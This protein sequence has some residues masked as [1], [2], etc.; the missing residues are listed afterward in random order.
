MTLAPELAGGNANRPGAGIFSKPDRTMNQGKLD[1]LEASRTNRRM[2]C[3]V[4]LRCFR[5]YLRYWSS[6]T[7]S[8]QSTVLP[9]S[10]S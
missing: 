10:C 1:Q 5:D 8:N 3:S 9:S 6:L 2:P 4:G 7:F